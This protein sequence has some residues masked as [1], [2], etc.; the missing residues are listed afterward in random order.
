MS[1]R[2]LQDISTFIDL[3][4]TALRIIIYTAVMVCLSFLVYILQA[5]CHFKEELMKDTVV[6]LRT[7]L[8]HSSEENQ[9]ETELD[10]LLRMSEKLNSLELRLSYLKINHQRATIW[11]RAIGKHASHVQQLEF[12]IE[13]A[14]KD[15]TSISLAG[16]TLPSPI[17]LPVPHG[18]P[19]KTGT[20]PEP[21]PPPQTGTP[22]EPIS[23]LQT[24]TPPEPIPPLQPVSPGV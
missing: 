1:L 21:S 12:L 7:V 3:T 14:T 18:V 24:G 13:Q 4:L 23:P 15:L 9:D 11:S 17:Y 22:P 2:V 8:S 5:D 10:T 20:P 16:C 19:L 6:Q